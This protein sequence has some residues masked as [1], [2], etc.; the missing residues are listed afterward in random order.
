MADWRRFLRER[1][2]YI[3]AILAVVVIVASLAYIYDLLVGSRGLDIA[4]IT[5]N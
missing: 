5:R 2:R 3:D 4:Y 1:W